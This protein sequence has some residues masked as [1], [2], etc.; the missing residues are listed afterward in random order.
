MSINGAMNISVSGLT[1][2][3]TALEVVSDNLANVDTNGFKS[4]NSRFADMVAGYYPMSAANTQRE[5][6]GAGVIE[7][8]NDFSSGPIKNTGTWSDMAIVG[9]GFFNLEN[10]SGESLYSRDGSF[11]VDQTGHLVNAMGYQ[12]IG[13]DGAAIQIEADPTNPVYSNYYADASGQIYGN[14]VAGG[15]PVAIGSPLRI[16]TFPNPDGLIRRGQN[17]YSEG[18]ESGAPANGV[19]NSGPRGS[20]MDFAVEGSNV[21][22]ASEMV[23]MIR[24][25]ADYNANSKAV[26]TANN[27]IETVVNLVR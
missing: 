8:A 11:H 1:S 13:N 15:D 6:S 16:S 17:M 22:L 26:L 18:F 24:Y 10:A 5:G 7:I 20:V 19:A 3:A 14:P 23:D 4:A 25:Q 2:F 12:V 21:D 9:N 27:M